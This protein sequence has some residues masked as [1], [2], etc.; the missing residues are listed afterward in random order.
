MVENVE[1]SVM[2]PEFGSRFLPNELLVEISEISE[3]ET[4]SGNIIQGFIQIRAARC[5]ILWI[6][7]IFLHQTHS[8]IRLIGFNGLLLFCFV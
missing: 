4:F 1:L 5:Q 3:I 8:F 7:K 2:F 6:L